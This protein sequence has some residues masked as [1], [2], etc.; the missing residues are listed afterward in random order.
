MNILVD[1]RICECGPIFHTRY[2]IVYEADIS[3]HS[4]LNMNARLNIC[5]MDRF[6]GRYKLSVRSKHDTKLSSEFISIYF[7]GISVMIFEGDRVFKLNESFQF[8]YEIYK[9]NHFYDECIK[10][11]NAIREMV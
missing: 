1:D 10:I 6:G 8:Y 4:Y 3:M 9:D 2:E 11:M 7:N 5:K